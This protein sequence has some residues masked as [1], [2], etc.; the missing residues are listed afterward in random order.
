MFK[1]MIKRMLFTGFLVFSCGS[2]FAAAK[3]TKETDV[4]TDSPRAGSRL[5]GG[6]AAVVEEKVAD[7]E[8]KL[9]EKMERAVAQ[10]ADARGTSRDRYLQMLALSIRTATED[11][12]AG[13]RLG[14][15]LRELEGRAFNTGVSLDRLLHDLEEGR[16]HMVTPP[17]GVFPVAPAPIPDNK[18]ADVPALEEVPA[19]TCDACFGGVNPEDIITLSCGHRL[20]LCKIC[21]VET[22]RGRID[23]KSIDTF[24]CSAQGC[25]QLINDDDLRR[26]TATE[27]ELFRRIEGM[28][29]L[30]IKKRL[31]KRGPPR[32]LTDDEKASIASALGA[33]ALGN[34][35]KPCPFCYEIQTKTGGCD[36][37]ACPNCDGTYCWICGY[38]EERRGSHQ[39]LDNKLC[40]GPTI[41]W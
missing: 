28:R 6:A 2:L 30:E 8:V 37:M 5:L 35:T 40:P 20:P 23:D 18:G 25:G 13:A 41:W 21:R 7:D 33:D 39:H 11:P 3:I 26:I 4:T 32:K 22:V 17:G 1:S 9:S 31:D 38:K 16:L 10:R 14:N 12:L 19:F 27:P 24:S 15:Y 34:T 36:I 29:E